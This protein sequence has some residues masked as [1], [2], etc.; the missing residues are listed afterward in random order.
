MRGVYFLSDVRS[1]F[2]CQSSALFCVTQAIAIAGVT[3]VPSVLTLD[4][5]AGRK[6]DFDVSGLARDS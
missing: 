6:T 4:E 2:A 1:R 3:S 5:T